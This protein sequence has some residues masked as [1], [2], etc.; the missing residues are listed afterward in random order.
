MIVLVIFLIVILLVVVD[1]IR[2][3]N[4]IKKQNKIEMAKQSDFPDLKLIDLACIAWSS[5]RAL[6]VTT[7]NPDCGTWSAL[8]DEDKEKFRNKCAKYLS[9]HYTP[10]DNYPAN[11]FNELPVVEQLTDYI[12]CGV[13]K[14][15]AELYMLHSGKNS[16]E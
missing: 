2:S 11:S 3:G 9:P 7:G 10:E 5:S 15:T 12:A 1:V 8:S 4:S 16:W 14:K 13:V 6:R